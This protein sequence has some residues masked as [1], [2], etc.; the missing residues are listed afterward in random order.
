M[1]SVLLKFIFGFATLFFVLPTYAQHAIDPRDRAP[2]AI[3]RQCQS[4]IDEISS[5]FTYGWVQSSTNPQQP[6]SEPVY[7]FYYYLKNHK[8]VM[9][10][11]FLNGGPQSNSHYSPQNFAHVNHLWLIFFDQRGTGCSS[12]YPQYADNYQMRYLLWSAIGIVHDAEKIRERLGWKQW[13]ILGQSYGAMIAQRYVEQSPQ[14]LNI[15]IAH[16]GISLG[17]PEI[18]GLEN[19]I[20][21]L[22]FEFQL[23][24]IREFLRLH[25]ESEEMIKTIVHRRL[26]APS[27]ILPTEKCGAALLREMTF[28]FT[29]LSDPSLWQVFPTYLRLISFLNIQ[30]PLGITPSSEALLSEDPAENYTA[31]NVIQ[32]VDFPSP[33]LDYNKLRSL[34]IRTLGSSE[35]LALTDFYKFQNRDNSFSAQLYLQ[36]I[37]RALDYYQMDYVN[38][39][40][41]RAN[42]EHYPN[43]QFYIYAAEWDYYTPPIIME[44]AA[45]HMGKRVHYYKLL[46][47]FHFSYTDACVLFPLLSNKTVRDQ[48]QLLC[49]DRIVGLPF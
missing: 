13:N 16:G 25:P 9:P 26:C 43:L 14:S 36:E 17:D 2:F 12:P 22:R 20:I 15:A 29:F 40:K 37:R 39:D 19:T 34:G 47:Q 10:T 31:W 18:L 27:F 28:S 6:D 33:Y 3:S 11:L 4:F 1:P 41:I 46:D 5:E 21:S 30:N 7:V 45:R 49:L 44:R 35:L 42:L 24:V 32:M 23:H 38:L 48:I 8:A